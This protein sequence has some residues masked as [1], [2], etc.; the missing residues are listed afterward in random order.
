MH[1]FSGE[2]C[3]GEFRGANWV[4]GGGKVEGGM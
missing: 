3:G 2:G 4:G 1:L